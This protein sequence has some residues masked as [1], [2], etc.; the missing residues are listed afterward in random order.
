MT[1]N[2]A[3]F[4]SSGLSA[5]VTKSARA[6]LARSRADI[7]PTR[8]DAPFEARTPLKKPASSASGKDTGSFG[9][10]DDPLGKP[11]K[12]VAVDLNF[13][14]SG[15]RRFSSALTFFSFPYCAVGTPAASTTLFVHQPLLQHAQVIASAPKLMA[16]QAWN[17]SRF[18]LVGGWPSREFTCGMYQNPRPVR[19]QASATRMKLS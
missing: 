12:C 14:Y 6:V 18:S 7:S 16:A 10:R 3:G 17:R 13:M 4:A 2:E 8:S 1:S 19:R 9:L 15:P 11:T 5:A